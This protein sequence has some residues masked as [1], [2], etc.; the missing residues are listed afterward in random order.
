[1]PTRQIY[2]N[3]PVAN[4]EA[5]VA[6]FTR[7]GFEFNPAF[8]DESATCMI[9]GPDAFAMLLLEPRFQDFTKKAICDAATQIEA[10]FAVSAESR[11]EVDELV[12]AALAAGAQPANEPMD[13]GFMYGRSFHDLDGHSWEVMWMDPSAME[14]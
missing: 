8:T 12:E 5:S 6:F 2:V 9:L 11:E 10:I 4:L 1:M 7:L 13:Q 3:L 14:Q